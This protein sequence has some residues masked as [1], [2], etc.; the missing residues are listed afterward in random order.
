[1]VYFDNE[2]LSGSPVASSCDRYP[3]DHHWDDSGVPEMGGLG[4]HFSVRWTGSFDFGV[5]RYY[6]FTSTSDD[7][8]R[9]RVDGVSVLDRWSSSAATS[10]SQPVRLSGLVNID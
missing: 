7:G 6:S 3:V 4:D 8:S 1:M 9:I 5:G 10:T 2:E